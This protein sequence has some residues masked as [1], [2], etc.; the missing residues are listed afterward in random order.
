MADNLLETYNP[1]YD[2]HLRQYFALPHMQKHLRNVGLL[3]NSGDAAEKV[4][5]YRR[6]RSGITSAEEFRRSHMSRSLSRPARSGKSK[7]SATG[8][9]Q[10]RH[11]N[12]FD[13]SE[14]EL[15]NRIEAEYRPADVEAMRNH[16]KNIYNR[17]AASVYKYQYLHKLDDKTLLNY[18]HSLKKQLQKLE[19]FRELSFGP[20]SVAKHHPTNLQTS[21]FFR[22]RSAKS[23]RK[24]RSGK[25][26]SPR[27]YSPADGYSTNNHTSSSSKP[28]RPNASAFQ[29][30]TRAGPIQRLPP[31]PKKTVRSSTSTTNHTLPKL[32]PTAMIKPTLKDKRPTTDSPKQDEAPSLAP[33]LPAIGTAAALGAGAAAVAILSNGGDEQREAESPALSVGAAP[34]EE[35]LPFKNEDGESGEAGDTET[36][37]TPEPFLE[38]AIKSPSEYHEEQEDV[39]VPTP[40]AEPHPEEYEPTHLHQHP[41]PESEA[42]QGEE[43]KVEEA[44]NDNYPESPV[45]KSPAVPDTYYHEEEQKHSPEPAEHSPGAQSP[46][47]EEPSSEILEHGH[48]PVL[49]SPEPAEKRIQSVVNGNNEEDYS[50]RGKRSVMEDEED[51][52]SQKAET[53]I[54]NGS[55]HQKE[56][57]PRQ[58]EHLHHQEEHEHNQKEHNSP[59]GDR[60]PSPVDTEEAVEE[61]EHILQTNTYLESQEHESHEKEK[62]D[63]QADLEEA[64]QTHTYQASPVQHSPGPE[65]YHQE[66]EQDVKESEQR[67]KNN[68]QAQESPDAHAFQHPTEQNASS[69]IVDA[70]PEFQEHDQQVNVSPELHSSVSA[71]VAGMA[72]VVVMNASETESEH[73]HEEEEHFQRHKAV[74]PSPHEGGDIVCEED[75]CYIRTPRASDAVQQENFSAEQHEPEVGT[76]DSQAASPSA[77]E[78]QQSPTSFREPENPVS[79]VRIE[80]TSSPSLASEDLQGHESE[81]SQQEAASSHHQEY[82]D[83]DLNHQAK[84]PE[85]INGNLKEDKVSHTSDN[86]DESE[87]DDYHSEPNHPEAEQQNQQDNQQDDIEEPIHAIYHQPLAAEPL[88]DTGRTAEREAISPDDPADIEELVEAIYHEPLTTEQEAVGYEE[89]Q[90]ASPR[91]QLDH[92]SKSP[93]NMG[94]EKSHYQDQHYSQDSLDQEIPQEASHVTSTGLNP[95]NNG[96]RRAGSPRAANYSLITDPAEQYHVSINNEFDVPEKEVEHVHPDHFFSPSS[97]EE[98]LEGEVTQGSRKSSII[99]DHE[100]HLV[101]EAAAVELANQEELFR[102]EHEYNEPEPEHGEVSAETFQQ[103]YHLESPRMNNGGMEHSFALEPQ[104]ASSENGNKLLAQP[105]IEITPASEYGG[106]VEEHMDRVDISTPNSEHTAASPTHEEHEET[107]LV[108]HSV[109]SEEEAHNNSDISHS[110]TAQN[111]HEDHNAVN[112]N[113]THEFNIEE[114]QEGINYENS[115]S[116]HHEL[117]DLD[118]H[119]TAKIGENISDE[120]EDE[121]DDSDSVIIHNQKLEQSHWMVQ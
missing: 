83:E 96:G 67:L 117:A 60:E 98:T 41:R 46:E 121:E 4:E 14:S 62:Y 2:V 3:E 35:S 80:V 74:L 6:I 30:K 16:S 29:S 92:P 115:N 112:G 61:P 85:D 42:Y 113:K 47:P 90:E 59:D 5:I 102:D 25:S 45:Q 11:S 79:D 20:N 63:H 39:S 27:K 97:A 76:Q 71:Q 26:Q 111:S 66:E 50:Y 106:S 89:E 54:R 15:M 116:M 105:S 12:C 33:I 72:E 78:E 77:H 93:E 101:P 120:E 114:H 82:S 40:E 31:L 69:E 57:Q 65:A 86:H 108:N 24:S 7:R 73:Q 19:R 44:H 100:E 88:I 95:A 103:E 68:I 118:Q 34:S 13:E 109:E 8:D 48:E 84:S 110:A 37:P 1:L 51:H 119:A 107:S 23:L 28:R 75:Q 49:T 91:S 38:E 36:R 9:R 18:M 21:W 17:L 55:A 58:E 43:E 56:H 81:K 94:E 64:Q 22:R 10:R 99:K 32:P 70:N 52:L 104:P 53:E 87:K